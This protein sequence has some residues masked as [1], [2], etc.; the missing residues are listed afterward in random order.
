MY[1][2]CQDEYFR[3]K[4]YEYEFEDF[5]EA[6]N[7]YYEISLNPGD[8]R[9]IIEMNQPHE[10]PVFRVGSDWVEGWDNA[11]RAE[12]AKKV[13]AVFEQMVTRYKV[14]TLLIEEENEL[15]EESYKMPWS[16]RLNLIKWALK[17]FLPA[18]YY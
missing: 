2:V 1:L 17:G 6:L 4:S 13:V 18:E 3:G 9:K 12:K 7:M 10:V 11:R 16:E 14:H 8:M 5:D 15:Y